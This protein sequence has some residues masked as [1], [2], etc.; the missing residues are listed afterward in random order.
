[1]PELKVSNEELQS[2]L[3]EQLGVIDQT[4]FDRAST[5]AQ[6]LRTPL[7]H[8]LVEQGRI[9]QAFLL[10]QLARSWN[11]GFV[12]LTIGH[13]KGDIICTLQE[14]FARKHVLIPFNRD[15]DQL[16]VA[17]ADPR[18]RNGPHHGT[19]RESVPRDGS[20]YQTRATFVQERIA[21][22]LRPRDHGE[23]NRSHI[24]TPTRWE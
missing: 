7:I 9:P 15:G 12:N 4:D 6:R 1:M 18:E 2:L 22:D 16:H 10:E 21:R 23:D 8:T 3:V 5:L 11:V 24:G 20:I 13:V 14:T 19:A 17:M